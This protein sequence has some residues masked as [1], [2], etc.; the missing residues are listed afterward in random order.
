MKIKVLFFAMLVEISQTDALEIELDESSTAGDA[1]RMIC[2]RFPDVGK[3]N[4]SI[5]IAVNSE[6]CDA[7]HILK[8]GDELA[9][10]PPISGG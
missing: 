3:F 1:F 9:L 4:K 6:Y 7:S 2:E 8:D 10:I 5:S